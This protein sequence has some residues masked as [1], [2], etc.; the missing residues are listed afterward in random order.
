MTWQEYKA[1]VADLYDQM[2]EIGQVYRDIHR[3]DKDTG[4][5]RQIDLWMECE[6]KELKMS[7][8]VDAKFHADPIDVNTVEQVIMLAD[9]VRADRAVIVAPNGF[10]EGAVAKAAASK[11]H[12]RTWSLL[13]ALEFMVPDF[14]VM[15][16]NCG[17]DCIPLDQDG[18]AATLGGAWLWWLAG[19]CRHCHTARV[20]CQA[21]GDKMAVPADGEGRCGC[22]LIWPVTDDGVVL[23][24]EEDSGI[25]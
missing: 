17:K 25:A 2:D 13:E 5:P 9:A 11:L 19:A 8:L 21:C 6:F 16:P 18:A 3:P 14:W 10:T 12:C 4:R 20:W 24:P 7:V 23:P 22:G 15:C 1:A